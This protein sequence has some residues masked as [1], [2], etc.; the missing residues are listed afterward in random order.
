MATVATQATKR[1]VRL[2]VSLDSETLGKLDKAASRAGMT[3]TEL[4]RHMIEELTELEEE[5]QWVEEM[6]AEALAEER[7]PWEQ[8]KAE[9]AW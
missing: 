8:A 2:H 7:I 4:L 1:R 6:A 3:R 9:L 5:R